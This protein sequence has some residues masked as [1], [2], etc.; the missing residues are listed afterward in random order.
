[1]YYFYG[2]GSTRILEKLYVKRSKNQKLIQ[3]DETAM[4]KYKNAAVRRQSTGRTTLVDRSNY[5]LESSMHTS[6]GRSLYVDRSNMLLESIPRTSTGR[7]IIDDRSNPLTW[8]KSHCPNLNK[9]PPMLLPLW[10]RAY[11]L[12]ACSLSKLESRLSYAKDT[13]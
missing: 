7:T 12:K 1:M 4:R 3:G 8:E 11:F 10:P 6:T 5:L 2:C 13:K 9:I